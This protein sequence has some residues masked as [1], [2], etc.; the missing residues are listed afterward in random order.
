MDEAIDPV[1]LK[2]MRKRIMELERN[3]ANTS[4]LSEQRMQK[5]I[6]DIIEEVAFDDN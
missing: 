5:M 4:E 6:H 3:N 1:K 2:I